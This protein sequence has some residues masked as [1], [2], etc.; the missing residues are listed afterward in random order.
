[1]ASA[2]PHTPFSLLAISWGPGISSC[3]SSGTRNL[4][5]FLACWAQGSPTHI[6]QTHVPV[7]KDKALC[8]THSR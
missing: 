1:M 6:S 4:T 7:W 5:R 2:A 8:Q 3:F